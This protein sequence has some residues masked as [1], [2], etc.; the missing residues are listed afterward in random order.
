MKGRER[1]PE[2]S[3]SSPVLFRFSSTVSSCRC[4][5][6]CVCARVRVRARAAASYIVCKI[7]WWL[8]GPGGRMRP[9]LKG[10]DL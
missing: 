2:N 10:T 4:V 9:V 5:C 1:K 8:E 6:V 7:T 3:F